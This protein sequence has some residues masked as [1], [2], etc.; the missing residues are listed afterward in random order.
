MVVYIYIYI[1][2]LLF[3]AQV[4]NWSKATVKT[5]IILQKILVLNK[6]CSFD[7]SIYQ[8]IKNNNKMRHFPQQYKAQLFSTLI[9]IRNQHIRM[10]SEGSC[11]TKDW[12][13]DA[14][15]TATHLH[16]TTHQLQVER[17]ERVIETIKC[18]RSPHTSYRWRGERV[19]EPIKCMRSPHTSYRWRGERVIE[20]IRV[21]GLLGGH[22][23]QGPV[24]GI[25]PGHR[26]Y[27][28]TLY[29][30]CHVIFNDHRESGPRFN[31]SSEGWC[32]LTV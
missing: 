22:D 25:W 15:N 14:E 2:T 10:I 19:I 5:F 23:W 9:T 11:D 6:C 7:I 18:M 27:T 24:G 31:I 16:T 26:G 13:N 20:P 12:S 8:I 4:L 30:K 3:C 21:W 28:P 1:L 32:F 17:R 29:E